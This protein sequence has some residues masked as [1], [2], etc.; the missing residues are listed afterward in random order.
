MAKL[1]TLVRMQGLQAGSGNVVHIIQ[2][3]NKMINQPEVDKNWY[4]LPTGVVLLGVLST[5]LAA[6][7]TKLLGWT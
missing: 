4:V 3:I 5:T 6:A 1:G 2:Q 7:I